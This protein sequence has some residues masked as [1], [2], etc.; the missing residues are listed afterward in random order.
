[1]AVT[2]WRAPRS[3]TGSPLPHAGWP[4]A[5]TVSGWAVSA[6]LFDLALRVAARDHGRP[7]PRLLHNPA[8]TRDVTVA[9]AARRTGPLVRVQAVGL[10]G[11]SESGSGAAG[12]AAL[13]RAAGCAGGDLGGG[14]TALVDTPAT[15]RALAGLAV[16]YADPARCAGIEVAAGSALAGWWVERGAHPGTTAVADVLAVSRQRF[17]LGVA[18]GADH[19]QAWRRA[20]AVPAGLGGLHIWHRAV[21][22]GPTVSAKSGFTSSAVV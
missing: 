7:V 19:A 1:M 20:L 5:V 12:L 16:A 15:L 8:P 17:M 2:T 3:R 21:T 4:M 10:D 18:A 14:P 11:R 6:A 13:A 22:G 9:V